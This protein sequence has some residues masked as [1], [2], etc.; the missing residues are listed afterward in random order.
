MAKRKL[1]LRPNVCMLVY[2]KRGEI[3]IGERLNRRGHWQF[4]QGGAEPD[5]TLRQNV[6]RELREELGIPRRTIKRITKLKATHEYDWK[7]I[8]AY[9]K[10][11]W[12][13]QAQTFW[14]VEY[15][16]KDSE[17]DLAHFD[18]PEFKRWRWASV[19]M[20]RKIANRRRL[21][22]YEPALKEFL[23]LRAKR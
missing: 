19:P 22:G 2:N 11:R 6:V 18:E 7:K 14:A 4:P 12:R 16:G 23:E 17:I 13:G 1:P 21:K 3:F 10:G 5:C 15:I 9:A 8:P 20:V